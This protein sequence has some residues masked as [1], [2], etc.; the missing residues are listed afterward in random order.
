MTLKDFPEKNHG[1]CHKYYR[2]NGTLAETAFYYHGK[3]H[4]V[5]KSYTDKGKLYW[6]RHFFQGLLH[7]VWKS[8]YTSGDLF[9]ESRYKYGIKSG[10]YQ[11]FLERNTSC[12][13]AYF[14][15]IK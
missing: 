5:C 2:K 3:R 14:I 13:K 10:L 12:F 1:L 6:E 4:G 8:Y 11:Q 15:S 7:G 9:W